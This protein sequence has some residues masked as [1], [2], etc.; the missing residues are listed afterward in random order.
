MNLN[1]EHNDPSIARSKI[2]WD[3][4]REYSIIG[5]RSNY[6]RLYINQE[7]RGVYINVEHVDE[8]YVYL[9]FGNKNGNLYKCLWPAPLTYLGSDP[10]LYK[11]QS[12]NRRAYD[13]KTNEEADDY[14]DLAELINIINITNPSNFPLQLEP[15]FNVNDFL[16]FLAIETATGH[17]DSYSFNQQNYYL[18][19]NTNSGKFEFIPYDIDNTLGIDWFG[20]DWG[21]RNIYEWAHPSDPRP[22]TKKI[23]QNTEYRNRYSYYLKKLVDHVFNESS[24]SHIDSIRD[25]IA[26]YAEDDIYRTFD[27]GYDM[28]DFLNSFDEETGAHVKYGIKPYIQQRKTSILQQLDLENIAPILDQLSTN[29]PVVSQPV[30]FSVNAEDDDTE[31]NVRLKYKIGQ[32]STLMMPMGFI[33][34]YTYSCTV[35]G[36]DQPGFIDYYIE[37]EDPHGKI[38]RLP[39]AG[40]SRIYIAG[41]SSASLKINELLASNLSFGSD[42]ANDFDDW[43]EIVNYGSDAVFLGDKYLTDNQSNPEKWQFPQIHI[44]PGQYLIVWADDQADQ[45]PL[46]AGFKLDK[47]GE[48]LGILHKENGNFN[49]VDEISFGQQETDVS[50]GRIPDAT[51]AF[52]LMSTPTPGEANSGNH[53]NNP[54]PEAKDVFDI[55]PNPSDGEFWLTILRPDIQSYQLTISDL[56]GRNIFEEFSSERFTEINPEILNLTHGVYLV[57]MSA[58]RSPGKN[59]NGTYSKLLI[60][61]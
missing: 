54:Y 27:Y 21:I 1:G 13:L 60:I 9:R 23:L 28:D 22:L 29:Y 4:F 17:W 59:L 45:G 11:Y 19:H 32:G 47:S 25:R 30:T 38:S 53:I 57:S 48:Y 39:Y 55:S 40:W 7:Y 51:G 15:I 56:Y 49:I 6:V 42:E 31:V 43:I 26:P 24:F 52:T 3:M 33:S 12:G 61:N 20:I 5:S 14:T 35:S 50:F 36:L 44:N 37:A 2:C 8:E 18:Y 10:D 46:H 34:G 58:I 16:K 41:L